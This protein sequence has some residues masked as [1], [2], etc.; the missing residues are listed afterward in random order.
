VDG[1]AERPVVG[2]F[3]AFDTG[4]VGEMALRRVIESELGRRRP[5]IELIVLAPFGA[6]HP[7]PGDEGRP[8]RPLLP[9][10][11]ADALGLD[12]LILTGDVLGDDRSWAS[13]YPV[14]DEAM[15]DRGVGALVLTGALGG[16][17]VAASAIWF[18]VG[19]TR[20]EMDVS[21]LEGKDVWARDL[22]TQE[23][24]GGTAAQSGDPV[25]LAGRVFSPDVLRRRADLLRLCG[26]LP[27]ERCVV[28]ETGSSLPASSAE[29]LV[30]ATLSALRSDPKLSVVVVT[31]DPTRQPP[32]EATFRLPGVMAERVHV[33]PAW[34][35]LDDIA[36]AMSG[37]VAAV[38]TSPP[39]ANLAASLGVPVMAIT[40]GAGH[41]FDPAIPLAG[42]AASVIRAMLGG[43]HVVDIQTAVQTLDGAFAELA[44]RL[45]RI[46]VATRTAAEPDSVVSA[47]AI[48]QQRLVD[49]RTALQAE[50][51]RVQSELDH[52]QSSPEHRLARPIREGYRRWQRRRT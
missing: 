35:G 13:R 18:A 19:L 31:L 40:P 5:D 37:S 52:L 32:T 15:S 14:P 23:R 39:G 7:I 2:L 4:E 9:G 26:A 1:A 8:A 11:G 49:E 16:R 17:E 10:A 21:G 20:G 22:A 34:A 6:E 45:P 36:A 12:A 30:E 3:G 43:K 48:L 29:R 41:R 46:G 25:L 50:L 47:L 28:I 42:D 38:A 27:A 44:Q 33:L 24:L 51:S